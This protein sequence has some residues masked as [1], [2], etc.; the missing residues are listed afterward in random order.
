MLAWWTGGLDLRKFK[1]A[2]ILDMGRGKVPGKHTCQEPG[3]LVSGQS[4]RLAH[5]PTRRS[6]FKRL[7]WGTHVLLGGSG[8]EVRRL[9]RREDC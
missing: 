9:C 7:G 6:G 3:T 4:P 2:W 8:K 1:K 5:Y